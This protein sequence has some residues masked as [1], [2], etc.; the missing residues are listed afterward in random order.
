MESE[1]ISE[2]SRNE[3]IVNEV[4]QEF[5]DFIKDHPECI[6]KGKEMLDQ[7]EKGG[8]EEEEV[9]KPWS[10]PTDEGV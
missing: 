9:F 8:V 10:F 7:T 5:E 4:A 3:E 1:R 6:A 2:T